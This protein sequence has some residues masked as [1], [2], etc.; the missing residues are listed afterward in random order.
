MSS[1]Q[2]EILIQN[3]NQNIISLNHKKIKGVVEI[4]IN[5]CLYF[6]KQV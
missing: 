2:E 5:P 6:I 4:L 1:I 3:D